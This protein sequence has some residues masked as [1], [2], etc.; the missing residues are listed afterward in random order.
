M[1]DDSAVRRALFRLFDGAGYRVLTFGTAYDLL[2]ALR[3][4]TPSCVVLDLQLPGMTG[5]DVLRRLERFRASPPVVV[6]TA[7]DR[8]PVFELCLSLGSQRCFGKPLDCTALLAAV[9]EIV[10][11]KHALSRRTDR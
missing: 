7:D 9:D 2:D 6:I 3:T 1:D 10:R 11:A 8:Q 5:I 4:D